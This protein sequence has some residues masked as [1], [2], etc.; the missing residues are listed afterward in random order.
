MGFVNRRVAMSDWL[1][2]CLLN[3]N[4]ISWVVLSALLCSVLFCSALL[5]LFC[6]F[7]ERE[8][9]WGKDG[10]DVPDK[11]GGEMTMMTTVTTNRPIHL[12]HRS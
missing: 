10:E 11:D 1:R 7:A 4:L 3:A 2:F 5:C 8:R 12:T 9:K 6:S